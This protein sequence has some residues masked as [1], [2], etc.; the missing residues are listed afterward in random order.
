MELF[1]IISIRKFQNFENDILIMSEDLKSPSI[2][3]EINNKIHPADDGS[4]DR[5]F[6]EANAKADSANELLSPDPP[7]QE[8]SPYGQ[9]QEIV[10]YIEN[11]RGKTEF[12]KQ[13]EEKMG[14]N[15]E[16]QCLRSISSANQGKIFAF[17]AEGS[18]K[19]CDSF[20]EKEI[21]S[22]SCS[23]KFITSISMTP[24]GSLLTY[25][26]EEKFIKIYDLKTQ[27]QIAK[28]QGHTNSVKSVCF[29]TDGKK[30]ASG[31]CDNSIKIWDLAKMREEFTLKEHVK[32]INCLSF[33]NTAMLL[34]SG[35]DD[36]KVVLWNINDKAKICSFDGHLDSVNCVCFNENSGLL[37]SGSIDSC[38][39]VWD[40]KDFSKKIC[41][42]EHK[43]SVNSLI[44][45]KH[46]MMNEIL[47]SV[48]DD[49]TMKSWNIE[50]W[51]LIKNIELSEEA[52]SICKI[53]NK[54]EI[55]IL[56]KNSKIS[57]LPLQLKQD[58]TLSGHSEWV[59]SVCFSP[60]GQFIASGS[61]DKT[62]K[63]WNLRE[64]KE[65][66]T[67]L[68]H[69]G[70][71]RSVCF[72]PD[73]KFVASGSLDQT[74]KLWNLQEQKE[75]FTLSGYS[76]SVESVCFSPDGKFVSSGSYDK[77]IKLWNL[78]EQKE[79]FTF[80][81][82]LGLVRSV[83]FSP[84]GKFIASCSD[85][86]RIKL[87]NLQ[88]KKEV[89]TF[90]DYSVF[91]VCFSPDGKFIA[92]SSNDGTIKLWNLQEQKKAFTLCSHIRSLYSV[93]FSPDGKFIASSSEDGTIKLWN[94]QEQIEVLTLSGYSVF[95]V[96]FSPDGKFVAS[97]SYN[98]VIELWN[99]QEQKEV[100]TLSDNSGLVNSVCFSSDGKLMKSIGS[101]T[102]YWDLEQR[103]EIDNFNLNQN[104]IDSDSNEMYII[105]IRR[106]LIL[107]SKNYQ[108]FYNIYS[109]A[110]NL[111]SSIEASHPTSNLYS[112]DLDLTKNN[113]EYYDALY[114][115]MHED[116]SSLTVKSWQVSFTNFNYSPLHLAA[117]KGETSTIDS[118]IKNNLIKL[119]SDA[120]KKS[121]LFYSIS[122]KHQTITDSILNFLIS[123]KDQ[124]QL[125]FDNFDAIKYDL[126]LII[127]NSS[128]Y[129]CDFLS[130][131]IISSDDPPQFGEAKIQFKFIPTK[132]TSFDEFIE[133]N[134]NI[135]EPLKLKSSAFDLPCTIGSKSSIELLNSFL[136][137]KNKEIYK[138]TLI[139]TFI[140]CRWNALSKFIVLY[141]ILLWLNIVFLVLLLENFALY[142]LIPFIVLNSF[143]ILWEVAEIVQTKWS[144]F[145]NFWNIIDSF[146]I[147]FTISWVL[148][149][150]LSI[151][152][153]ELAW[154]TLLLNLTRGVS[155]FRAFDTT[156][157]YIR[158]IL[159]SLWS[160]RTFILIFIYTTLSFGVLKGVIEKELS[161]E[162]LWI[163]SF[164]LGFGDSWSNQTFDLGY[165]TYLAAIVLN[166]LL[167]LNMIISILGDSFDEF[168]L[169]AFYY[170]HKEMT[171]VILEI[172]QIFS[173]VVNKDLRKYLHIC[174]NYYE[175]NEESW[176]GK[177]IDLRTSINELENR[178][179]KKIEDNQAKINQSI[180][181]NN[182]KLNERTNEIEHKVSLMDSKID[183]LIN[184]LNSIKK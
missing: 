172:E 165:I 82:H 64:Q 95:S 159:Q 66:F 157:Y 152:I 139:K 93:C 69:S 108:F 153:D 16:F 175:S 176:Q 77:T 106:N 130:N 46:P 19:V 74:I 37:A 2:L 17:G 86:C 142:F 79:A 166:V 123:L 121:P 182:E 169:F 129:I 85:D 5:P 73:G 96:C 116:Y 158:L 168:Q 155:G 87:W 49:Q 102:K 92:S 35:A 43:A 9:I 48:S 29:S 94:L 120:F 117:F 56:G 113:Q 31:S 30:L 22:L 71:V 147:I 34:A 42:K 91:S 67:L 161:F 105:E 12:E 156:R 6:E 148:L 177:V 4:S 151:I 11:L 39:I 23:S 99:L 124:K 68:G 143:L 112:I 7:S 45:W 136:S 88:E 160:I 60:D 183:I 162:V 52:H 61:Y 78:R 55:A 128:Q 62:I 47:V 51:N 154:I 170:D 38:L 97:G 127:K 36:G 21:F 20:T 18:I 63:L 103:K 164:G 70:L 138:T 171:Q 41:I 150:L 109:L 184:L 118:A 174:V 179:Y 132:I 72:S 125:Y 28:L 8:L 100:F 27:Q 3:K 149:N 54:S 122:G 81:G 53:K 40:L 13:Y 141:T 163:N 15:L 135:K 144:Y 114:Y 58:F 101:E 145:N 137:S 133:Y 90:S 115:V 89:L 167:M 80:L 126:T 178:L 83:C 107:V 84:D 173:I 65:A 180:E 104:L 181:K 57:L 140:R 10:K 32:P 25:G 75:V 26:S 110:L 24:D 76:H 131:S 59:R 44:F 146:R 119:T 1:I 134:S 98:G 50:M 111:S 14:L 33:D